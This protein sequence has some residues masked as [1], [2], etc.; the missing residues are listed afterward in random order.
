MNG[1]TVFDSLAEAIRAAFQLYDRIPDGYLVR[2]KTCAGWATAIV[3]CK[4]KP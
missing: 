2:T 4:G 1:V 3:I